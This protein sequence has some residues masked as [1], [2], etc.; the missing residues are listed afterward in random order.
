VL[1]VFLEAGAGTLRDRLNAR[2]TQ[3]DQ[4]W[5]QVARELGVPA[6]HAQAA[7]TLISLD[8]ALMNA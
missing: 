5:A 1:N 3:P 7:I 4:D 8:M 2:V 6:S